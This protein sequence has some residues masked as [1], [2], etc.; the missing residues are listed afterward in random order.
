[1]TLVENENHHADLDHHSSRF[2]EGLL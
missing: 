1:M 2:P